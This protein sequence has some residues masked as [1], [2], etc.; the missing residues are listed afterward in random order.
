MKPLNVPRKPY[1]IDQ[2]PLYRIRGKEKFTQIIGV[3]WEA[4]AKLLASDSY[5][6]W[7]SAKGREIQAPIKWM[8]AVHKKI[9]NYLS[10][11]K[12]PD[13]IYSQKHRSY[14][15]NAR[16]HL[17]NHPVIKTDINKFYPSVTREMVFRTFLAEFKCAADVAD[18]IADIVCYKQKHLPTGSPL[19]GRIALFAA[20]NL[21]DDI[22]KLAKR[23]GCVLTIYVDDIT[24]SGHNAN[25]R[26]LAEVRKAIVKH[27]FSS[28]AKK[29]KTFAPNKPKAITGAIVAG[30]QLKLPNNRHKKIHETRK[31]LK[32]ASDEE[33]N[34]LMNRLRGRRQEAAQILRGSNEK[35]TQ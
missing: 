1:A 8:S 12:V 33:K 4:V 14:V 25:K 2:S 11:I 34:L 32:I 6:V 5:H 17:G 7:T 19:S 23:F 35:H 31:A 21:F 29:S 10:R 16:R 15:E 30:C 24:L 18:R 28:S 20:R 9:G 13:Y 22:D 27:G 3:E 26:L